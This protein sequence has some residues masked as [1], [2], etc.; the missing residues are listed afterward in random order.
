MNWWLV[1][2]DLRTQA[3]SWVLI[4]VVFFLA[5]VQVTLPL[6]LLTTF[7]SPQFITYLGAPEYDLRIDVKGE[8][9]DAEREAMLAAMSEDSRLRDGIVYANVIRQVQGPDGWETMRLE[10]GDYSGST[11]EFLEG[12]GP[13]SGEVALSVLNARKLGVRPGQTISMQADGQPETLTV[14]GVYQDATSGGYT[15]KLGGKVTSGA[16][17]YIFY[18]DVGPGVDVDAVASDYAQRFPSSTVFPMAR[19]ASQTLSYVTGALRGAALVS[20][21]MG[22]GVAT[23]ITVLFLRLRLTRD[24]RQHGVLSALGFSGRELAAQLLSKTLLCVVAGA[25]AGVLFT[26]TAGERLAGAAISAAGMGITQLAFVP[27][28]L[29]WVLCPLVL[30]A[31]GGLVAL[32]MSRVL[33]RADKSSWLARQ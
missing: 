3:A 19:Y 10:A 22:I 26:V 7:E 14:S 32:L 11:V 18:A 1:L 15:A 20:C 31:C 21:V 25:L 28:P 24:R 6:N 9:A 5:A 12:T 33:L 17:S 27:S 13:R 2:L 30:V 23:L 4:P 8:N 29:V 16:V